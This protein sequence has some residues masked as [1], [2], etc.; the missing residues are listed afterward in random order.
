MLERD[1]KAESN[2]V[3]GVPRMDW[4]AWHDGYEKN[5]ALQKRL[6]LVEGQI[7]QCLSTCQLGSIHIIGVCAGD[8]R[9]LLGALV[10]HP[11][12]DDVRALLVELDPALV[13]RGQ[14][15]S[16]AVGLSNQVAFVNGDATISSSYSSMAPANIVM[17]C[18]MLGL[19]PCS[20]FPNV[21]HTMQR[22]CAKGG[23]IVWTRRLDHNGKRYIRSLQ[24][25]MASNGFRQTQ[26]AV[27]SRG[28]SLLAPRKV[29]FAVGTH[30]FEDS[31]SPLRS[32]ERLFQLSHTL[33]P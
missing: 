5:P 4:L 8:G 23:R 24:R 17:M 28:I 30:Q 1:G 29:S 20:E 15:A 14:A 33:V 16:A 18:G 27:T 25:L 12:R 22:L 10:D 3:I 31:P 11:R 13:R 6:K 32:G 9:D 21:V 7:S 2:V 19:V 26:Y